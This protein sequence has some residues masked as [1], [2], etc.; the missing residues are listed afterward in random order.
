MLMAVFA[1]PNAVAATSNAATYSLLWQA[2]TANAGGQT[3]FALKRAANDRELGLF[4]NEY[5]MA[6]GQ[7]IFWSNL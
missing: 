1:P 3:A 4:L 5:L 2:F 6:R 7:P